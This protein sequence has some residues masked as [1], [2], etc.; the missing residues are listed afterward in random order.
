M[1]VHRALHHGAGRLRIH[2]TEDAVD[3]LV[4]RQPQERGAE[5]LLAVSID[6]DFHEALGL[7]LF[8]RPTDVYHGHRRDQGGPAALADLS[9]R[10]AGATERRVHEERIGG[11]P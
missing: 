4:T 6:Q 2:G 1:D 5:D 8:I 7:A 11:Y 3:A 10:H 9:L